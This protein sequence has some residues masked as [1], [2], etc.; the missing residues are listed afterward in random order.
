MAKSK[1][2]YNPRGMGT[3]KEQKFSKKR[4]G[5]NTIG[6]TKGETCQADVNK[7]F[8]AKNAHSYKAQ[9]YGAW[10]VAMDALNGMKR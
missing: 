3:W 1:I 9:G 8:F 7:R 10:C 5:S 6:R 2:E 4:K